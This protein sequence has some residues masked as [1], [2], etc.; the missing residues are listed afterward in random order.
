MI[1]METSNHI[2]V[3]FPSP[4]FSRLPWA[5]VALLLTSSYITSGLHPEHLL[6]TD[7]WVS[8]EW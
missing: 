7:L 6:I 3:N 1:D 2:I 5:W 8:A 4:A